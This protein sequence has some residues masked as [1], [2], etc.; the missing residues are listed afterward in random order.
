[1][2]IV[3]TSVVIKWFFREPNSE[4]ALKLLDREKFFYAP[5]YLKIEF[6]SNVT[7]KVRT[8][9]LTAKD[10]RDR[11]RDFNKIGFYFELNK[12]LEDVAFELSIQY[13]ITF[14]D[15]FFVALAFREKAILY[16]F[17]KR[18]MRSVK[19]TELETLIVIPH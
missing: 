6:V 4:K 11:R 8:G 3:D 19:G 14:Y 15:A 17:D 18:L 13:P 5:D 10:G 9:L 1:M 2:N 7:K 16:T 12:K